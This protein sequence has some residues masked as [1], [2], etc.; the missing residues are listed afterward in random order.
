MKI[1]ELLAENPIIAAVRSNGDLAAALTAPPSVLFL[2]NANILTLRG[3]IESV[4]RCGKLVLVHMDLAEG[5]GKDGAGAAYLSQL[6]ADGVISTRSS[7]I[8]FAKSYGLCAVQRFFMVDSH[9]VVTAADSIRAAQPD[10]VELMPG[11][12]PKVVQHFGA[13][14]AVPV[15]AGGLIDDKSEVIAALRAGAAAVSTGAR[16]LWMA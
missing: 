10:L 7:V 12:I 8:R 4:H 5:L 9:S 13:E 3:Q 14:C 1:L 11:I 15:I 6:G 16:A 2:L